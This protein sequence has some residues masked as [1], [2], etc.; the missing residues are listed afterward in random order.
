ML[1]FVGV[2]DV[3]RQVFRTVTDSTREVRAAWLR[4]ARELAALLAADCRADRSTA[5]SGTG[6]NRNVS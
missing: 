2:N 3:R 6:A 1:P 4:E 5:E